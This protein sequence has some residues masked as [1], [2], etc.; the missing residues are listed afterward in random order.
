MRENGWRG[1][2]GRCAKDPE[3]EKRASKSESAPDLVK[4]DFGADGP[5]IP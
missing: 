5:K 1:A 4:R 2:A 3:K